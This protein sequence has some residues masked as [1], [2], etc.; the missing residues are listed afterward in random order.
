MSARYIDLHCHP[1]IPAV[2]DAVDTDELGNMG[3]PAWS[4]EEQLAMMARH[5]IGASVFSV[6]SVA[7]TLAG[8]NGRGRARAINE[9]LA[10]AVAQD[11]TRFGAFATV[12]MNDMDAAI[13][14][15]AYALDV[16][17][18]DGIGT[19][20]QWDGHHLGDP[21]FDPWLDELNRRGTTLFVHPATPPHFDAKQSR[22]NVSVVE[23]MFE[24]TRMVT[25]MV[26]SGAKQR[27]DR[28]N[29]IATHG[30]GTIP[31]LAQ[32]ISMAGSMPWGFRD[33]PKLGPKDIMS[34]LSS[35]HFDLTAATAVTSLDG[36]RGLVSADNLLMGFDYP[37]MP[38]NTIE[39]AQKAFERY[40][41]FSDDD[42][43][44]IASGNARRL[45]PRFGGAT[46]FG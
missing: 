30:G 31:Y 43:I 29:I 15:T 6:N 46:S 22:T 40:A 41:G 42:K 38:E 23:F 37:L 10:A 16:L 33:G 3:L 11:P 19:E 34:A 4:V 27:F 39:P 1:L 28:I 5:A 7:K 24:T 8:Q 36:L 25:T 2:R 32:R 26:L 18:L 14:E 20:T 44:K 17:K 12:P 13:E 9:G 35:F 45:L 21:H